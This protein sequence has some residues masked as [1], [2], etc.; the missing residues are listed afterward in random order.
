MTQ[1]AAASH[2]IARLGA[3]PRIALLREG[4]KQGFLPY[5]RAAETTVAP[6]VTVE[7]S[8]RVML[9]SANYLGLANHPDVV[10][11][12]REAIDR[13]GSTITG[14]RLLNGTIRLHTELEEELAEWVGHDAALVFTTGYQANLGAI[15]TLLGHGDTAIVDSSDH[16]SLLDGC[17][18]SGAK[19]RAF[20]HNRVDLASQALEKAGRDGGATLM[21]VDGLY[22]M[23]GDLAVL[24]ELAPLCREHGAALMV[25]EAH[26]V[27][28][29]GAR[30]VG[31]TELYGVED[32]VDVYMGSLSKALGATGGFIAGSEDLIDGLRV[33]ARPFLFT[34]AGVPAATG[35]A[36][37]A[38]RLRRTGAGAER[39]AAVLDNARYLRDGL[40]EE[41]FDVAE[42]VRLPD[43]S[44]L[45]SPIVPVRIGDDLACAVWWRA[46]WDRGVFTSA[47]MHPAVPPSGALLRLCVMA[48]H[49]REHLA[50]TISAFVAARKQIDR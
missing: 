26:S 24:D 11:G 20:V 44:D 1:T 25:D 8:D 27:G 10:A 29:L 23:K 17:T 16:A 14:S 34:T 4:R 40:A 13:Y 46:L 18:L 42:P 35:A 9:A 31:A 15:S 48:T 49:T 37:A 38:V 19:T 3:D 50:A 2:P 45:V 41:G 7:G 28:V 47:A 30:G 32:E 33:K 5:F 12:A 43:G 6:V 22:S 39:A 21:V 36:L